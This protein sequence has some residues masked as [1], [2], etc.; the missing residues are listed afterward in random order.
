M[1]SYFS[2]DALR[3]QALYTHT[4]E[5]ALEQKE[6]L[7]LDLVT[8]VEK[9]IKNAVSPETIGAKE[10]TESVR[11]LRQIAK[12][13]STKTLPATKK[14]L[15]KIAPKI[16]SIR[17]LSETT[18]ADYGTEL[19][20]RVERN[21]STYSKQLAFEAASEICSLADSDNAFRD[22]NFP[23]IQSL[24]GKVRVASANS[25][26][27]ESVETVSDFAKKYLQREEWAPFFVTL[28]TDSG[29]AAL[30]SRCTLISSSGYFKT[31][32]NGPYQESQQ[33][34]ITLG[35]V[36]DATFNNLRL[37]LSKNRAA[38]SAL[39]E[40]AF[41][42]LLDAAI[43][44]DLDAE[45]LDICIKEINHRVQN[46]R[47]IRS[48]KTIKI[49]FHAFD[50]AAKD[51]ISAL[52]STYPF[53]SLVISTVDLKA[54]HPLTEE[55]A[56]YL[57][58]LFS[59]ICN[60]EIV[61][62]SEHPNPVALFAEDGV[63]RFRNLTLSFSKSA[64]LD[65]I[66]AFF[67]MVEAREGCSSPGTSFTLRLKQAKHLSKES[68]LKIVE[69]AG[70]SIRELD[71]DTSSI[72]DE[73]FVAIV[74]GCPH[75]EILNL[76]SCVRLSNLGLGSIGTYLR[77]LRSLSI[78]NPGRGKLSDEVLS[79]I[80]ES[81]PSLEELD[82]SWQSQ[83]TKQS[84]EKI[85]QRLPHLRDLKLANCNQVTDSELNALIHSCPKLNSLNIDFC[86]KLSVK[87]IENLLRAK[88]V[89]KISLKGLFIGHKKLHDLYGSILFDRVDNLS[90]EISGSAAG[91]SSD[92]GTSDHLLWFP[93]I[94]LVICNT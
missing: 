23:L 50:E 14:P 13:I 43:A 80:L 20:K 88:N 45:L 73:T 81:N 6:D 11:N 64:S 9:N 52:F 36:S 22:N 32:L 76:R 34:E 51:K 86:K 71:L 90:L 17:N 57:D 55:T 12:I 16:S 48:D 77:N 42:H 62:P 28:K 44:Y 4:N 8:S 46:I 63:P 94:R 25:S 47:L 38:L 91:S 2:L 92:P 1:S 60:L 53:L 7:P 85:P 24:V 82:L 65:S 18:T 29:Q 69:L 58:S 61:Y 59:S 33:S 3:M 79:L 26:F 72:D 27:S 21:F 68:L 70:P 89:H 93:A 74:M 84:L 83:L 78:A 56:S 39:S 35:E 67:S 49:S 15:K 19:L 41:F 37:L 54:I 66:E 87:S 40:E 5:N 30:F 31:M 10:L 75:L